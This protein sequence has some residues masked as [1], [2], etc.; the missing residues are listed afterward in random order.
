M[1]KKHFF[2][3]VLV[4]LVILTASYVISSWPRYQAQKRLNQYKEDAGRFFWL[5]GAP[6][7][8][9]LGS[10]NHKGVFITNYDYDKAPQNDYVLPIDGGDISVS[11]GKSGPPPE[12][13]GFLWKEIY[14]ITQEHSCTWLEHPAQRIRYTS[15]GGADT[16]LVYDEVIVHFNK[17]N[18]YASASLTRRTDTTNEANVLKAFDE[19]LARL[20]KPT[21][22][23]AST[24]AEAAQLHRCHSTIM[25]P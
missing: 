20:I 25:T 4:F 14:T 17:D 12:R 10:A 24:T 22:P 2:F 11:Y 15:N 9:K 16:K 19:I 8:W 18:A 1:N 6:E 7:G 21:L 23:P 3:F 5:N 13:S